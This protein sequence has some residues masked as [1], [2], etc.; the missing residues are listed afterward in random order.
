[1]DDQLYDTPPDDLEPD[2]LEPISPD[3]LSYRQRRRRELFKPPR[4]IDL[5]IQYM[6]MLGWDQLRLALK[7]GVHPGVVSRML[8]PRPDGRYKRLQDTTLHQLADAF[9]SEGIQVT[10]EMLQKA[11]DVVPGADINPFDIP[12]RW[13]RLVRKIVSYGPEIED[14]F[15][16]QFDN[17]FA[18][19]SPLIARRLA[20]TQPPRDEGESPVD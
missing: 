19:L 2:E 5:I 20:D 4:L 12:D 11:R 9:Q 6:G 3:N 15:F 8:N 1:M 18:A 14:V 17:T 13:Q 10:F 16:R 7:L